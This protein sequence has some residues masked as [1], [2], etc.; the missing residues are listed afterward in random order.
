[1]KIRIDSMI[2]LVFHPGYLADQWPVKSRHSQIVWNMSK[3][4][5]VAK[6]LLTFQALHDEFNQLYVALKHELLRKL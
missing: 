2:C 6:I 5:Y 1:M 4:R 3:R